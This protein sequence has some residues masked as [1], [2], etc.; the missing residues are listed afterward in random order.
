MSDAIKKQL[1]VIREGFAKAQF[2]GTLSGCP[3]PGAATPFSFATPEGT[4]NGGLNP[5]EYVARFFRILSAA[6]TPYRFFDFTKPGV[7]KA[8]VPLFD[9]LTLYGNHDANVE[10]WKGLCQGPVWDEQNDPPGINALL[11]VDRIVAPMIARGVE[12]K[13]LRSCSV[14]IWFDYEKS[15]PNLDYF[16]GRLGEVV[17][18]EIV[19]LIVTKITNAGEV[20]IV[21]EGEDPHAKAL[22]APESLSVPEGTDEQHQSTG[23]ETM[24]VTQKMAV[25]LALTVGADIDEAALEAALS[26]KIEALQS[27]IAGLKPD[28]AVGVQTL[29]ETRE[30]AVTLYKAAK[31]EKVV[32][33]FITGVIEKADLATARAFVEEYQLAV[34]E[35]IPLACPKCGEKLSRRSSVPE[36]DGQLAATGKR[37]EDYK[38]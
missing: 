23:G 36:N 24:K 14:T 10:K 27:E 29:K 6:M 11:A 15:H 9:G 3:L 38:L 20:S 35:S 30:K 12:T 19:R 18:G 25:L 2:G 13:A 21:W 22:S 16:W 1:G 37:T 8:A 28:A 31:G 17:D 26:G 5:E 7:L 32:E 34:D 4:D 33:T